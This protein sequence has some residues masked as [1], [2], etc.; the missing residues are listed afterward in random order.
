VLETSLTVV[1]PAISLQ[2]TPFDQEVQVYVSHE[3]RSGGQLSFSRI[4]TFGTPDATGALQV[5]LPLSGPMTPQELDALALDPT[6]ELTVTVAWDTTGADRPFRRSALYVEANEFLIA[7]GR[8]VPQLQSSTGEPVQYQ[9]TTG[10]LHLR[11]LD[12]L[13]T[14][15]ANHATETLGSL[16]WVLNAANGTDH[17]GYQDWA[18]S[19]IPLGTPLRVYGVDTT[20]QWL[21][22]ASGDGGALSE[23]QEASYGAAVSLELTSRGTLSI[24]A[25]LGPVDELYYFVLTPASDYPPVGPSDPSSY[26]FWML[27]R[28]TDFGEHGTFA[29]QGQD[30]RQSAFP[31]GP[32]KLEQWKRSEFSSNSREPYL[33]QD[34]LITEGETTTIT[35]P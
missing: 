13:F 32:Y 4:S 8:G 30:Q 20:A 19:P 33:V 9:L 29:V 25:S 28:V 5:E 27:H 6:K 21:I 26:S 31:V 23:A 1:V 11:A 7:E 3:E 10:R 35:V 17:R 22:C 18:S 34:V 2:S 16:H 12:E 15:Q 24:D 14:V